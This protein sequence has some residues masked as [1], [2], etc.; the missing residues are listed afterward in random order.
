[1]GMFDTVVFL[2][3]GLRCPAGHSLGTFQTKSFP[4]PSMKMNR[5]RGQVSD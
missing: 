2:D 3:Q 1:M 4:E 5:E